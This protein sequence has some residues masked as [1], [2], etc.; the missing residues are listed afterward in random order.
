M[1]EG[2]A[3]ITNG[4]Y[5][6][7]LEESWYHERSEVRSPDRRWYEQI[8]C[9]GGAFIG[10]YS[11]NP[12]TLHLYTPRVGNAKNIWKEIG[13]KPS[14]RA[15][16]HLDGEVMLYFSPRLLDVVAELAGARRKRQGKPLTEVQKTAFVEG[17]KKGMTAL[18][19]RRDSLLSEPKTGSN[20]DET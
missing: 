10:L 4:R 19:K 12:T 11:E 2:F 1:F 16:F 8:P 9:K 7:V 3:S 20:L 5:R 17:R 15:D 13:N 6:V 18:K 14:C